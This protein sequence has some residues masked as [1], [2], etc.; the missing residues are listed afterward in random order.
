MVNAWWVTIINLVEVIFVNSFKRLQNLVT[1]ASSSGASTS[2]NT[3][4]GEGLVKN[5]ANI[6]IMLLKPVHHLK[7]E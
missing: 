5:T 2:S 7:V 6:K 3:Q 4:I 1:F